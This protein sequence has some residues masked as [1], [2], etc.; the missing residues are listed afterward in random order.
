MKNKGFTLL[1]LVIVIVILGILSVTA[2]PRFLNLQTDARNATLQGMMGTLNGAIG[3][4]YGK[5][6]VAGMD[7]IARIGEISGSETVV[8][9]KD[10]PISGCERCVFYFG[11]P[12]ADLNTLPA[13]VDGIG[14]RDQDDFAVV[15]GDNGSL[16]ITP[17]T[18]VKPG[19]VNDFVLKTES[20]YIN[21]LPDTSKGTYTL[22]ITECS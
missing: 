9:G 22:E 20:C 5:L 12:A 6:A 2:A 7:S 21:Y 19:G 16:N 14:D 13:L 3:I 17:T 10:I 15:Y 8:P 1:E 11:V 4:A 18:N